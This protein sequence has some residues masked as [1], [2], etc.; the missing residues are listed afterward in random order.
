MLSKTSVLQILHDHVYMNEISARSM[1]KLLSIV[2]MQ[3]RIES[4]NEF[5]ILCNGNEKKVIEF[6]V[7]RDETMPMYHNLDHYDL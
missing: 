1:L 5:S 3:R 7:I 6:I 4:C 2:Q